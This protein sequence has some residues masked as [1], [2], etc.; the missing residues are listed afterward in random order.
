MCVTLN[1][2]HP[3]QSAGCRV[4]LWLVV[5]HSSKCLLALFPGAARLSISF[6]SYYPENRSGRVNEIN[7]IQVAVLCKNAGV[8]RPTLNFG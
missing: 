5:I 1:D 7:N 6:P 2:V 4:L 8:F 3:L